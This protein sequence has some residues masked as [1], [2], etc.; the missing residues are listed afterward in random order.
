MKK[1]FLKQTSPA[2]AGKDAVV[3]QE[4]SFSAHPSDEVNVSLLSN[5]TTNKFE[6]MTAS[7]E[8]IEPV[9]IPGYKIRG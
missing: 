1:Y 3:K 2:M 9:I 8:E 6:G 7:I 4:F 5:A